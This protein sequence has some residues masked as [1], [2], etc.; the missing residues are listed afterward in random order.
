MIY[1]SENFK[2]GI[3]SGFGIPISKK[4]FSKPPFPIQFGPSETH[5]YNQAIFDTWK[6]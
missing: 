3:G 1:D 2:I 4:V 6:L 5:P